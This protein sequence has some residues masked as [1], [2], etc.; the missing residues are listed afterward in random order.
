MPSQKF[1]PIREF[2]SVRDSL[3]RALGQSVQTMTGVMYPF[4]DMYET[5]DSIIIR[6][7]P[8][9][10][11]LVNVEV[12]MEEDLLFINGETRRDEENASAVYLL[13]ERRFGKFSRAVR[14]PSPVKADEAK[15]VFKKGVL[16]ITLPKAEDQPPVE[17]DTE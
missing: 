6:T 15:A 11:A 10:G 5:E 1:D 12:T 17:K 14:I 8:L 2:S 4:L 16:T 13:R 3:S 9:D 7:T